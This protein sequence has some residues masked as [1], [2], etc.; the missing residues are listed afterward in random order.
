MIN[1]LK[2]AAVD[3]GSNAVRLLLAS[4]FEIEGKTVYKKMSLTRMPIRLGSDA[5]SLNRISDAKVDEL[6]QTMVGFKHLIDA[7]QPI[8]YQ[9]YATSAIRGA[10]NGP[11]ICKRVEKACGIHIDIIDGQREAQLIFENKSSDRFGGFKNYLY[12]DVG[13]GSTEITL[14]SGGKIA[15]SKSFDIGTI[16]ILQG[17]VTKIQWNAMRQW[18]KTHT[19]KMRSIAV[20]G[21]G[22]NI[23]KIFSLAGCKNGSA[24][25]QTKLQKVRNTLA[26]RSYEQRILQIGLRPDR[27]DVI[28]PAADIYL[29]VSQW[30][31]I[32]KIFVPVVGLA[33]GAVHLLYSRYKAMPPKAEPSAAKILRMR[34]KKKAK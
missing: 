30:A 24:L 15:L 33:D 26:A 17:R 13:G 12:V 29:N 32:E 27:A 22:G 34:A 14:F 21:S 20:I 7:Y 4:V 11:A 25:T 6:V 28:V 10:R 23:N 19:A 1:A 31:G 3:I 2:F 16:R 18:L 9:A 8:D 5:F